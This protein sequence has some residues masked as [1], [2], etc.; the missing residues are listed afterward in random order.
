M[1]RASLESAAESSSGAAPRAAGAVHEVRHTPPPSFRRGEPV[2][3]TLRIDGRLIDSIQVRYRHVN[4]AE[5]YA[6]VE[7]A[8]DGDTF[9]ATIPAAYTDSAYPLQYFFVLRS[10]SADSSGPNGARRA[11]LYPGLSADLT[12]Q[13]YILVR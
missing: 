2:H 8:G 4:Q 13:P 3:L 9:R 5:R 11:A 6:D 10:G 1:P 7:T 12:N